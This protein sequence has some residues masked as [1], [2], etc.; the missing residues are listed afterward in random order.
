M[1]YLTSTLMNYAKNATSSLYH[2]RASQYIDIRYPPE[3]LES[4]ADPYQKAESDSKKMSNGAIAGAVIG[5]VAG[6]LLIAFGIFMCYLK[7]TAIVE[8]LLWKL[9]NFRFNSLQEARYDVD[10]GDDSVYAPNPAAKG[11]ESK[12]E[13]DRE[14]GGE[15]MPDAMPL[16]D[17]F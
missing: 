3:V 11:E 13:K 5:S 2:G 9:G 7:R 12:G 6:A 16:P 17:D 1:Q 8:W 10:I 4:Y 14:L 15:A